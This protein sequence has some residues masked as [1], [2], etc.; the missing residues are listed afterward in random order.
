MIK[1]NKSRD[2][3]LEEWKKKEKNEKD[4]HQLLR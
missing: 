4:T 1:M 3:I 2:E